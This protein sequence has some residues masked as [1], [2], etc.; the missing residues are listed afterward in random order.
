MARG[1]YFRRFALVEVQHTFYDPPRAETL[2]RWREEAPQGF[3]F[4]MKAWQLITHEP[5]S[6]TY[7][8][9]RRP[10]AATRHARYGSFRPTA[11]VRAAWRTTL[12]CARALGASAIVFQCPASF[13]PTPVHI[14]DLQ[15]FFST[16]A[17]DARGVKLCWEPR[18]EWPRATVTALCRELHLQHVVDPLRHEPPE[19]EYLYFRLHGVSG[20]RH[21]YSDPELE[22]LAAMCHGTTYCLFNNIAMAK[23][24]V[25]FQAVAG[26]A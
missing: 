19:S 18:G 15:R 5:A 23:D 21:R 8:R 9:L 24:A 11:E 3:E 12:E 20:Y 2:A 26:H 7:R 17:P 1:A 6:P 16:I 13:T 14:S 25:R 22:R 10:I 4:T